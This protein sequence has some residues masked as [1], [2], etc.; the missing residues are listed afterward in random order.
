MTV[1]PQVKVPVVEQP[2]DVFKRQSSFSAFAYDVQYSFGVLHY[3]YL[4]GLVRR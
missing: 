3:A 2:I 1:G 4:S